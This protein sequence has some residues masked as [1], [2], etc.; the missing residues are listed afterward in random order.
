MEYIRRYTME[1]E[2]RQRKGIS[3]NDKFDEVN[4]LKVE[5]IQTS[6]TKWLFGEKII[7]NFAK[8][9]N[10]TRNKPKLVLSLFS[11]IKSAKIL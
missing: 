10:K 2:T 8:D 9:S 6:Y 3:D 7:L 4:K 11:K 5:Y 1:F